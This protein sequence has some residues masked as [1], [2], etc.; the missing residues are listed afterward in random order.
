MLH[1][2]LLVSLDMNN[3]FEIQFGLVDLGF[4]VAFNT[5]WVM[6]G[7]YLGRG[8]QYIQ[9][10]KVLYYKLTTIGKKLLSFPHGGFE[11]LI[12]EVGGKC[13]ALCLFIYLFIYLGF[14]AAFNN[15]QVISRRVVRRA[16]ETSTYSWSRW[17]PKCQFGND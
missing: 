11:Q 16:E 9:L 1:E 15:V 7:S 13:V 17:L 5:V 2:S 6:M 4:N 12:S 14:Y 8:N 3:V 10:V